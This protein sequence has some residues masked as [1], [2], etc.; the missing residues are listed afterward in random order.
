LSV[1]GRRRKPR[2]WLLASLALL[3]LAAAG[4]V[5]ALAANSPSDHAL[6]PAVPKPAAEPRIELPGQSTGF[7]LPF[8]SG[9]DVKVYQGW[10]TQFS[11]NGKAA[12]AYDFGLYLDT[13]VLAAAGGIVAFV[14]DGETACGGPALRTKANYV[15]IY[16][17]DGSATQY[18]HLSSVAVNVGDLV[19]AGQVI[20][21]SGDTGYTGCMPHL[22]FARQYQGQGVSQ[23]VPVYF[24][25]YADTEFHSGDVVNAP[26]AD[27]CTPP[28]AEGS[29]AATD[30][31]APTGAGT[32]A[33]S[34]T[35]APA[36]P[37]P[38]QVDLGAFCGE[39][40]LGTVDYL[41]SFSRRDSVLNFDWREHGPGG[42]WLDDPALA[43]SARWS[44]R[45]AFTA[46]AVYTI[47]VI[48]SGTV[49][50]SIDGRRIADQWLDRGG[51]TQIVL[52]QVVGAGVHRIDVTYQSTGQGMLKLGWGRVFADY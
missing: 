30:A 26:A 17:A 1:R 4:P 21:K 42:Y 22:H 27:P 13:D 49:T 24:E 20:G 51:P 41:V 12:F 36:Q 44:G 34:A 11:H 3:A 19:T 6:A 48:W 32:D 38:I 43:F 2:G 29:A 7:R 33:A 39:Y 35:S 45:F 8:A 23:S 15:T 46:T 31:T 50:M 25:G 9:Q 37:A 14:H 28:A 5:P 18:G 40:S 52:S 10:N 47:A 16:H